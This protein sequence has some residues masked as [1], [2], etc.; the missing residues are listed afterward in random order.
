MTCIAVSGPTLFAGS[1]DKSV[2]SWD[3]ATREPGRRYAGHSDF[4]KSV[5]CGRLSGVEVLVSGGADKKIVVWDVKTG[6]RMHVLQDTVTPM[7]AVQHLAVDF[8]GTTDDGL[9][10][11]SASSD[12]HIRRWRISL[13]GW[14]Q[15]VDDDRPGEE[16]RT[17]LEHETS[18]YRLA[19]DSDGEELWTASG[20][21]TAKRLERARNLRAV[22]SLHHGDHVRAVALTDQWVIT[23]GRDEDVKVWKRGSG[24][25]YC[26]LQG[27]FDEITDLV[28][29]GDQKRVVS[30]SL[31]GTVRTWPLD[32]QG[33]DALVEEQAGQ[34]GEVED[35]KEENEENVLTAEEEAELA[36]LMDDD[37]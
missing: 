21:G 8:H 30:V 19:F 28:V 6:A 10:L 17:Y 7:G 35:E 26:T 23:A 13:S 4:V 20:D 9:V 1:W 33:L 5:V 27:H 18:V 32:V 15:C 2:W 14:E 29:L 11:M 22:E 31:D 16:R 36:E 34:K 24:E 3:L 37:E 12:P 25:L